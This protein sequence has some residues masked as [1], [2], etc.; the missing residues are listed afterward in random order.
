MTAAHWGISPEVLTENKV[1]GPSPVLDILLKSE[2]RVKS[3]LRKAMNGKLRRSHQRQQDL[4]LPE[5]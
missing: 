3:M 2:K 5:D 4:N 1:T